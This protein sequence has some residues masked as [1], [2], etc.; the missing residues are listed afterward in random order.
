[1]FAATALLLGLVALAATLVPA[2]RAARMSP[3]VSLR[4]E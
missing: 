4:Y 3:V 1:V 2:I